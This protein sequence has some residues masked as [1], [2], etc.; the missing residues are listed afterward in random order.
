VSRRRR[1]VF[2]AADPRQSGSVR[3]NRRTSGVRICSRRF[4][5]PCVDAEQSKLPAD[6]VRQRLASMQ[7]GL[8]KADALE[9]S[10]GAPSCNSTRFTHQLRAT[11][12]K[13]VHEWQ[14]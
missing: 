3:G 4:V 14:L 10:L 6:D 9:G 2:S 1:D 11:S 12:T 7:V 8:A 5:A 13:C